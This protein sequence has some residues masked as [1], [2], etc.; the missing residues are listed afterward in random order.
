M[1]WKSRRGL[2]LF[3][4][5]AFWRR[6]DRDF[7]RANAIREFQNTLDQEIQDADSFAHVICIA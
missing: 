6:W 1:Y 2:R 7:R 3:K 4:E 5:A